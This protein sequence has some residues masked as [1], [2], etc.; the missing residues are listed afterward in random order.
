VVAKKILSEK[1]IGQI[2]A[3]RQKGKTVSFIAANLGITNT[4]IHTTLRELKLTRPHA[5]NFSVRDRLYRF[6]EVDLST[7]CI[8]FT[9]CIGKNGY[10]K[11]G[12]D[13]NIFTAHRLSYT[14]EFGK[15]PDGL[16]VCHK[17]DNRKCINPVHLFLGTCKD[18]LQDMARKGRKHDPSLIKGDNV[19]LCLELHDQGLLDR[20]IA[21]KLGVERRI[22]TRLL[23]KKGIT[24]KMTKQKLED[25]YTLRA[26]GATQKEIGKILGFGQST[27]SLWMHPDISKRPK[28]KD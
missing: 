18:N 17:C 27:I 14:L 1:T 16:F 7:G 3:L 5:S 11:I 15:I 13:K 20:E 8:N 9:G 6:G 10:G 24:R 12:I 2:K 25:M 4:K 23:Q 19:S 26:E 22:V 21:E 28:L